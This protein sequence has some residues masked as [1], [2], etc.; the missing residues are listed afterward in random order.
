MRLAWIVDATNWNF[1][2]GEV[3]LIVVGVTIALAATLRL[4]FLYSFLA[5]SR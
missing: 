2:F 4:S 5:E 3:F 1:A